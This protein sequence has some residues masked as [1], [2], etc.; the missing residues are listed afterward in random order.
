MLP[1]IGLDPG[2]DLVMAHSVL[3]EF[4]EVVGLHMYGGGIPEAGADNNPLRYKV[5]WTFEGVL[6]SYKRP[7]LQLR[8]GVEISVDG[9]RIFQ[10]EN[11]STI[12]VP[13]LG[14]LEAYPNGNAVHYAPL[15][16]LGPSLRTLGRFA[17][18]WPGHCAFWSTVAA[19]G[20]L[21]DEP[22]D[23]NGMQ[24]PPRKFMARL[25]EPQLRFA[26][27]ERDLT[28]LR[29]RAW[30]ARQGK[31][32]EVTLDLIDRRDLSTGLFAMNRTVGY[33]A[34]I[35][36]QMILRGDVTAPGVRNPARDVP[37]ELFFKELR[38]RGME[39]MR[40]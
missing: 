20:F 18:R 27:Y 17:V 12:D 15:F 35:G 10:P 38:A 28:I 6:G 22:I 39:L 9:E 14:S 24:V 8:D 1:E 40:R 31:P 11:V 25:L 37:I 30:G 13:G 34:S 29:V 16:G 4:D 33:A 2:I 36:A 5:T 32:H 7:A 26:D 19:L 3:S 23:V 21:R